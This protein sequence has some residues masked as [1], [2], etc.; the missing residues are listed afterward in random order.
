MD[1]TQY[2]KAA[3]LFGIIS[4]VAVFLLVLRLLSEPGSHPIAVALQSVT[5]AAVTR[6]PS[7]PAGASS[8]T[9]ISTVASAIAAAVAIALTATAN[10]APNVHTAIGVSSPI[11]GR[12]TRGEQAIVLARTAD[13]AWLQIRFPQA[14]AGFG[15]VSA[16]LMTVSSPSSTVPTVSPR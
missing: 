10:A 15:W 12:L 3:I 14:P 13:G 9:P 6:P 1:R 4:A 2:I 8:A 7:T 5:T 16:D 11:V